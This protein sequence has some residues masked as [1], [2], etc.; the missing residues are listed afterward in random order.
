MEN[1]FCSKCGCKLENSS[2][3]CANCGE[4]ISTNDKEEKVVEKKNKLKKKGIVWDVIR[5]IIGGF[6]AL[7]GLS[8]MINGFGSSIFEILFAISLMPF[9]YRTFICKFVKN[10]KAL[11]IIQLI[12]PILL[13][14][15]VNFL[16]NNTNIN[17]NS[18]TPSSNESSQTTNKDEKKELTESDKMILKITSLMNENLAFDTGDYIKGDIPAGEYAFIRFSGS[19]QYY[20][21][22]DS[23]GNIIENE[24]FDSFGYVKVHEAGN[25]TTRGVL[26]SINAFEKLEVTGAKQL[27]E[28]L[29]NQKDYNEGGYYKVGVDI[30]A[31][32][33][34]LES[35][36]SAYYAVMSG[37]VGSSDII[38]NDNF[39]GKTS[40]SVRD[41]Q[42]L[43]VSRA[44][45][46]QQ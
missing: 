42:Y 25:L 45:I 6:F 24:N 23:A 13:F 40:V 17:N 29:N 11:K 41:G 32:Q 15:L 3:F 34:I 9:I 20:S 38:K 5:Y 4:K 31:G 16:T 27:Y 39:N 21:E 46:T 1:K 10:Y 33:Y 14:V 2:D 35:Y 28:I 30:P 7:V 44:K 8:D 18:Y 37:P 43:T 19:G 26:V 22:E 12:L 36:S